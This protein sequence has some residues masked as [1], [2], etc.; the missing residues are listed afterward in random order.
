MDEIALT[1][2]SFNSLHI[3][4][5]TISIVVYYHIETAVTTN[6]YERH[7]VFS[8]FNV[9]NVISVVYFHYFSVHKSFLICE[10]GL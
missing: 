1:S 6:D 3:F 2:L 4:N 8:F 9:T 10:S 7:T 5:K